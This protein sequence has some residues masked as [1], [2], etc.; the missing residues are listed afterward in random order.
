[1]PSTNLAGRAGRWSADHRGKAIWGWLVFVL[2][3]V[4]A[5]GAVGTKK[6]EPRDA[7]VGESRTADQ[8]LAKA[9]DERASEQILFQ[10]RGGLTADSPE[11]EKAISD[12]T[13]RLTEDKHVSGVQSPLAP[14]NDGLVSADKRSA[15]VT[16]ELAGDK[17][18]YL[19]RVDRPLAEVETAS[20]AHPKVSI[21]EFG[22]ASAA[23]ALE[24][25]LK[26]DFQSAETLSLPITLV[27]LFVAFGALLAAG[28]PVLLGLTAVL[29]TLGIVAVVSQVMPQ[30]DVVSSVVL[31]IGLAVG[32]DYSLFYLR[33]ERDERAA[34]RSERDALLTAAAT[35]GHAVLISGA[36]VMIAMAGMFIAGSAS[37][38]SLGTGTILVVAVSMI[39][40]LTVL[41]AL[42]A[43][44]G[45]RIEKGRLPL[46]RRGR[47]P[48]SGAWGWVVE[49]VLRHPW[50]SAALS[51]GLLIALSIPALGMHTINSGTEGLPRNLPIMRTYDRLIAAFPGGPQ[52]AVVAVKAANVSSPEVVDAI[53]EMREQALATGLIKQPIT[54]EV[55]EDRTVARVAMPLVGSGTDDA[56]TRALNTLRNK[57]IPSTVGRLEGVEA[58]VTGMTAG[59]MDFSDLQKS[60]APW[61]F[62]F[63]LGLAFALLLMTFRS[64]VIPIKA[65][66]LNL[67]SVGAAYGVLVLIFQDGRLEGLLDFH[68]LGGIVSWLPL[69]LFV[70]LFGLSM[71]YHVFIL[72]RVREAVLG[73]ARTEDAVAHGIRSTA[74]TVTSAAV[75]MVA[76][77][78]I[79]ATLSTLDFKQMGVGLAV[80]V[81]IDATIVRAVLLP[82]TMKLLG[83]RN[84]Y[85]PKWLEWVPNLDHGQATAPAD[86]VSAAAGETTVQIHMDDANEVLAIALEKRLEGALR[87]NDRFARSNGGY[88]VTLTGV[89]SS[90]HAAAIVERLRASLDQPF[91]IG[92]E[93]RA[94]RVAFTVGELVSSGSP[95]PD[96][97]APVR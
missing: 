64:I 38:R 29:A 53:T 48:E 41:P 67:L 35:S 57:V 19:D 50:I 24:K 13:A 21:E 73:G 36:T 39:G 18:Q 80:A 81:L 83:E 25:A 11:V 60:R 10:G 32:V 87:P 82:A 2:A 72:T 8:L 31:L 74:G 84:W 15:L 40:S 42:L 95:A 9:F 4:L 85:M 43:K 94:V 61:V 44:L 88:E 70:V 89:E 6:I 62:L 55:S 56:S 54:V 79:F 26:D 46:R 91:F 12:V 69:F 20:A 52:P 65:I 92:G 7:G 33:R 59:T 58:P 68:S 66:V 63:V 5:M 93:R 37:F 71:D 1:M 47:S 16:F 30:D 22:G 90:D 96:R 17:E 49:R 75:V 3:G 14:G 86:M 78:A 51:G 34:G 27:I 23:K 77:F 45:D 97:P 28:I 76:V